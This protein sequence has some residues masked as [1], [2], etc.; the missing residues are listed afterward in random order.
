M[1]VVATQS[2]A[3]ANH[4]AVPAI[5]SDVS[6]NGGRKRFATAQVAIDSTDDDGSVFFLLPVHS[7]W[8][9]TSIKVFNDAITSGT[10]FNLGLYNV[11]L[12]DADENVYADAISLATASLVGV[13][14]AF[15]ARNITAMGRRVWE[16]AGEASNL[17]KWYLLA[18]TGVTVGSATG[19]VVVDVTY[20]VD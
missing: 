9:I 11:D 1:G 13:E 18:L 7:S 17:G 10:D 4:L 3:V 2:T 12:T 15:E 6:I 5:V 20:T 8:V 16:D 14:Q 19:D